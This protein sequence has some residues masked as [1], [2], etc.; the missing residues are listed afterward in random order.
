MCDLLQRGLSI[1]TISCRPVT[2]GDTNPLSP[3]RQKEGGNEDVKGVH[4]A[5]QHR[6]LHSQPT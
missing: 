3:L 2:A 6:V 5:E 1:Q 4:R